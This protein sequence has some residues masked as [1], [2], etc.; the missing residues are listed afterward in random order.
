MRMIEQGGVR[1]NGE[2]VSDK[3]LKLAAGSY[4]RTAGRQAQVREGDPE[5][6]GLNA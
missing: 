2:K 5:A 1:V 4:L 6:G 3:A